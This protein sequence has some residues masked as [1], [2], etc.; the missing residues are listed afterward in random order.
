M[1]AGHGP[2]NIPLAVPEKIIGLTLI[3]NFFDR[4]DSLA[5]LHPPLAALGSLPPGMFSWT[6]LS[7]PLPKRKIRATP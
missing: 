7:N 3:L 1:R 2:E 6:A 5:S 4:Y